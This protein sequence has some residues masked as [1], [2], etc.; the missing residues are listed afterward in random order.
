M[1]S[2]GYRQITSY[3]GGGMAL[4]KGRESSRNAIRPQQVRLVRLRI[5]D[6]WFQTAMPTEK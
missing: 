2:L 5:P 4:M 1:S 3:L 6:G